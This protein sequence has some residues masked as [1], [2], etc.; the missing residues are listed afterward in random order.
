MSKSRL[1]LDKLAKLLEKGIVNYKDFS[2]EIFTIL[3]SKREEFIYKMKLAT[4]ED[5]NVINKRLEKI[6]KKIEIIEKKKKKINKV[7]K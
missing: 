7:K 6:E 2:K 1:V 5:V 3:N 4:E